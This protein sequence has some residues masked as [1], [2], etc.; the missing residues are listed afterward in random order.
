[1]SLKIHF[2]HSHLEFFPENLRS[3][4][5]EN[6]ERFHEDISNTG[7]RCQGKWNPKMLADYRWTLKMDIP[8]AVYRPSTQES[9]VR[10]DFNFF[11]SK[12]TSSSTLSYNIQ[13]SIDYP[14]Q[15][16]TG[17]VQIIDRSDNR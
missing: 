13:Y 16:G 5:D 15:L 3:V 6:G 17:G 1:M 2:L 10:E 11:S 14:K 9:E 4:S 8:Q 12:S 7:A